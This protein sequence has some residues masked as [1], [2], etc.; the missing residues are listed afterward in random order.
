MTSTG[1]FFLELIN[2]IPK[3]IDQQRSKKHPL[4]NDIYDVQNTYFLIFYHNISRKVK[5]L[6]IYETILI[7]LPVYLNFVTKIHSHPKKSR[8]SGFKFAYMT[9]HVRIRKQSFFRHLRKC[10]E[11]R[12]ISKKLLSM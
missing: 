5:L 6:Y 7:F 12:N 10:G 9:K 11:N 2:K 4:F 8:L 1:F 3:V